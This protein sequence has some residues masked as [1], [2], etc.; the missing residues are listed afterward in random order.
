MRPGVHANKLLEGSI[1][2]GCHWPFSQ[3]L[4]PLVESLTPGAVWSFLFTVETA[5][6]HIGMC[7]GGTR[8]EQ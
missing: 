3:E 4:R 8:G 7:G 2:N 6:F 5:R 1:D